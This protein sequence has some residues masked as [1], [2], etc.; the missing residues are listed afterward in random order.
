MCN[1]KINETGRVNNATGS[2][3]HKQEIKSKKVVYIA[4][5]VSQEI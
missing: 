1:K 3:E 2:L 4:C 5:S